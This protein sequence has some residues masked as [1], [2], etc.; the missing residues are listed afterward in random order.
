MYWILFQSKYEATA[1]R[2]EFGN[3]FEKTQKVQSDTKYVTIRIGCWI[4]EYA[5]GYGKQKG[6]LQKTSKDK[7]YQAKQNQRLKNIGECIPDCFQYIFTASN[8]V[9]SGK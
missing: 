5:F 3:S 1:K 2:R 9:N 7:H 6:V 4:F 8:T